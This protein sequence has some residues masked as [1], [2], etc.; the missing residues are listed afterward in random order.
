MSAISSN[1][2]QFA[3][4][5]ESISQPCSGSNR[6]KLCRKCFSTTTV[7]TLLCLASLFYICD[8][9]SVRKRKN[10]SIFLLDVPQTF[11][12][13]DSKYHAIW[14][15]PALRLKNDSRLA[16]FTIRTLTCHS[17]I[18]RRSCSSTLSFNQRDL[19]LIPDTDFSETHPLVLIA[20]IELT[21]S[22]DQVFKHIPPA[23]SHF[24]V[25]SVADVRQYFLNSVRMELA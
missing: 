4:L 8:I 15:H 25:Y 11:S 2:I 19:V 7:D 13:A 12:L 20:S 10:D 14:R 1:N 23:S 22:L 24:H 21:P 3:D 6:F 5:S 9:P 17:C 18:V 16:G